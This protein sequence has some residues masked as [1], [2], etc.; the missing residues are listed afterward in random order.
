MCAWGD[1]RFRLLGTPVCT[2]KRPD[3]VCAWVCARF[4]LLPTAQPNGT[5]V[6]HSSGWQGRAPGP[7]PGLASTSRV[8]PGLDLCWSQYLPVHGTSGPVELLLGTSGEAFRSITCLLVFHDAADGLRKRVVSA[9]VCWTKGLSPSHSHIRRVI[10]RVCVLRRRRLLDKSEL[11]R[12]TTY[13]RNAGEMPSVRLSLSLSP[14]PHGSQ[15]P[16]PSGHPPHK[17][18]WRSHQS[19]TMA[20]V[21]EDQLAVAVAVLCL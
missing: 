4:C 20:E 5:K 19:Q 3:R 17:V 16:E 8:G 14:Q 18:L 6:F 11:Y 7:A 12:L 10:Q 2:F 15:H 9:I 1:V 21:K 13:C